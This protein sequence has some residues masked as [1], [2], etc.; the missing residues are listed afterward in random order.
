MR[1]GPRCFRQD[2]TCPDVL[3]I[4]LDGLSRFVYGALTLSGWPSHAIPLR[5]LLIFLDTPSTP[6]LGLVWA[7][8]IS[9]A[10]TLEIILYFLF[11][12][13]LRCF[14][15]LRLAWSPL[16]FH[17]A[18]TYISIRWVPPFGYR[19]VLSPAYCSPPRFA[20]CCVLLR[21]SVPRHSPY[22]LHSLTLECFFV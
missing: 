14:S 8:S 22:A 16:S 13:V 18:I 11:L 17:G 3:R 15:S 4:C 1:D 7:P 6:D 5:S 9:L 12:Q 2:S 21:L 19:W 10:T 20:V